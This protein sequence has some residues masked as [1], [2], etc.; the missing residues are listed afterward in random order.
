MT[1]AVSRVRHAA[2]VRAVDAANVPVHCGGEIHGRGAEFWWP[3]FD[4]RKL[5]GS[6]PRL[7]SFR[8]CDGVELERLTLRDSPSGRCT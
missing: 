3:A 2:L 7:L 6:R 4:R 5:A 8:R 1:W